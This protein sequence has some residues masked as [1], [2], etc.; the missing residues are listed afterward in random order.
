MATKETSKKVADTAVNFDTLADSVRIDRKSLQTILGNVSRQTIYRWT[1]DGTLPAP[2]K[3]AGKLN[4]W[5]VGDIR[6]FLA[7]PA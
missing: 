4:Y 6:R 1:K 5:S 3:L 2:Q 7:I